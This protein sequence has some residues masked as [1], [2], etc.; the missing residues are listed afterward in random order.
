MQVEVISDFIKQDETELPPSG[1]TQRAT[2]DA[3]LDE[4]YVLS[5]RSFS[6]LYIIIFGISRTSHAQKKSSKSVRLTV[7]FEILFIP[8]YFGLKFKFDS[9]FFNSGQL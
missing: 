8:S 1:Y 4:I 6:S 9:F 3:D 5:V 7:P 2:L